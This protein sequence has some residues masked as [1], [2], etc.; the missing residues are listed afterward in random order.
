[1]SE[2]LVLEDICRL[3]RQVVY[4]VN[5]H[6]GAVLQFSGRKVLLYIFLHKL[7]QFY[8]LRRRYNNVP[9]RS[10]EFSL[11]DLFQINGGHIPVTAIGFGVNLKALADTDARRRK[12]ITKS[13][14]SGPVV[15]SIGTTEQNRYAHHSFDHADAVID[16]GNLFW[17]LI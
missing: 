3:P 5:K 17:F 6:N 13:T 14:K 16:N 7:W 12:P 15:F 11:F 9:L 10:C 8:G 4:L 2:Q 1:M